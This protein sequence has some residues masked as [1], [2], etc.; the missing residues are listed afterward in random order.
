M[1]YPMIEDTKTTP[2]AFLDW[3]DAQLREAG[4]ADSE[5]SQRAGLS[6]SAIYEIRAGIRPGI[7]KCEALANLFGYP[8]EYVLR[9]AGHLPPERLPEDR[10]PRLQAVAARLFEIWDRLAE[11]D[12]ASLDRLLNI[13]TMQ[14]EMVEAAA[15]ASRMLE[16]AE[17]V[18]GKPKSRER[19]SAK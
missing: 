3:L 14:A 11:I 1:I 16:D 15:R 8:V 5:A 17:Q 18:A 9:L 10:D 13:V 4:Y 19:E 2:H 6:H 12:P 7:K